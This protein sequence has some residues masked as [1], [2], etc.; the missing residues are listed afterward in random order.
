MT[1]CRGRRCAAAEVVARR[2]S[3]FLERKETEGK[4]AERVGVDAPGPSG[5]GLSRSFRPF[6][7]VPI[8]PFLPLDDL[9]SS[10]KCSR[11]T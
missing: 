6:L 11:I 8:I 9:F 3:F 1:A 10:A 5:S 7:F 4:G 2:A